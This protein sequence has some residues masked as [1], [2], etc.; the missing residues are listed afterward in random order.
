LEY[1]RF[2]RNGLAKM[3]DIS[4]TDYLIGLDWSAIAIGIQESSSESKYIEY[5]IFRLGIT[6]V[7]IMSTWITLLLN[8][9]N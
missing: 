3:K 1:H 4:I 5:I 7:L 8:T 6:F 9:R 2:I